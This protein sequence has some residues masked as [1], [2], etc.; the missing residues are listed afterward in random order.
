MAAETSQTL[1]RGVRVLE[2]LAATPGGLTV[3][4]LA[5]ALQV[6]RTVMHRLVAT[7]DEHALIRRD[8]GGRI[9]A[10][11][12]LLRLANGVQPVL[13]DAAVP[14]LR[15]LAERSGCTAHLT[16]VDGG[17]ALALAVVEPSRTDFHVSYRVGARHRLDQGAAGRAVLS[18]RRGETAPVVSEG[19]LQAGAH[20]VAAP[21]LGVPG[22]EASLGVVT[23]GELDAG[24]V[25][26]VAAAAAALA[27]RLTS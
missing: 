9:K 27:A 15:E 12:G 2:V 4:E 21:V 16:I 20:G 18:G 1:D 26:Q 5:A 25:P 13:R 3:T 14:L 19:E 8:E 17:E 22:L 23:L 7:L 24:V 11:L 6:N 10:G